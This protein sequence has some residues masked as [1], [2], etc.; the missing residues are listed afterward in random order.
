MIECIHNH[1][2]SITFDNHYRINVMFSAHNNCTRYDIKQKGKLYDDV[3]TKS[4]VIKAS[5]CEVTITDA[6][7]D[8]ILF[9]D[10]ISRRYV[11]PDE[12][13]ELIFKTSIACMPSDISDFKLPAIRKVE[14]WE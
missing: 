4:G 8:V 7:G 12:L 9:G 14:D 11:R 5:S 1:A 6:K 10:E 3:M 13:A 2:F